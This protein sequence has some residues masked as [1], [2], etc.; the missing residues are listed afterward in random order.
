MSNYFDHLYL[1]AALV[2]FSTNKLISA[3]SATDDVVIMVCL[4]GE[5]VSTGDVHTSG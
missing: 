4:L 2:A 3:Q 5:N 1:C